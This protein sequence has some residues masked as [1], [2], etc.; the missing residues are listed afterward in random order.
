MSTS[1]FNTIRLQILR[2]PKTTLDQISYLAGELSFDTTN[3]ELLYD[4]GTERITVGNKN[5]PLIL[6]T[7]PEFGKTYADI[8]DDFNTEG[9]DYTSEAVYSL[10]S[11][12]FN[13]SPK[14]NDVFVSTGKSN[15]NYIFGFTAKI[16]KI[17]GAAVFFSFDEIVLFHQPE[18]E[19][20]TFTLE[21]G[22]TV[23]KN[24]PI[25]G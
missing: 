8:I 9:F 2:Q 17:Q 18:T 25:G 5:L 3:E 14:V 4:T 21:D 7:I 6:Q 15:D 11:S 10:L 24:I 22:T 16:I 12:Y 23:T 19:E 1:E 20:W 13:K